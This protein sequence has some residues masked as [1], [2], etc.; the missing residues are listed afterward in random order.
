[1]V[2]NWKLSKIVE[3]CRDFGKNMIFQKS[4]KLAN[5]TF[6]FGFNCHFKE[7]DKIIYNVKIFK[8]VGFKYGKYY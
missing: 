5:L 3:F 6:A 1:M 4:L 2:E 8:C 7:I